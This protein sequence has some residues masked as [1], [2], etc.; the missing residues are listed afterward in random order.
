MVQTIVCSE[1]YANERRNR[2][3]MRM[4]EVLSVAIA[5]P[6]AILAVDELRRRRAAGFCARTRV[7]FTEVSVTIRLRW[8][9][10]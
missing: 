3:D 6:G 8:R 2:V 7:R 10:G 5:V 1:A 4:L 9:R